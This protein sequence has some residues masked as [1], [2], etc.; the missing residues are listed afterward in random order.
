MPIRWAFEA[1]ALVEYNA[2]LAENQHLR[3]LEEVIGFSNTQQLYPVSVVSLFLLTCIGLT[4]G[5]LA[6]KGNK[7]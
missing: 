6:R 7:S 2:F 4:L 5:L 1:L 3:K